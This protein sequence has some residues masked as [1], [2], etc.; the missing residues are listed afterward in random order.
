MAVQNLEYDFRHAI[1]GIRKLFRE[2]CNVQVHT[3]D[4]KIVM[5]HCLQKDW[6]YWSEEFLHNSYY[7]T[8]PRES[9]IH[10][11]ATRFLQERWPI[12]GDPQKQKEEF[13]FNLR[14]I[15]RRRKWKILF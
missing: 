3:R 1:P 5:R 13:Y 2:Y 15:A 10:V 12:N 9:L 14:V 11:F 6:N 8:S 7:D 4:I